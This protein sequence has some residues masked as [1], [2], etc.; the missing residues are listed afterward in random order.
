MT[1]RERARL[2]DLF[3]PA[4]RALYLEPSQQAVLLR[5]LDLALALADFGGGNAND[6]RIADEV[7][8]QLEI[9]DLLD[10]QSR[11][12]AIVDRGGDV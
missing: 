3:A 5:A 2:E 11:I 10:E 7:R 8:K 1:S 9:N 4:P 6:R 12:A